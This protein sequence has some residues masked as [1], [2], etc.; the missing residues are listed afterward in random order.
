M[1]VVTHL[2]TLLH[3]PPHPGIAGR[4]AEV[5]AQRAAALTSRSTPKIETA[6]IDWLGADDIERLAQASDHVRETIGR[7]DAARK[8]EV[9]QQL[10]LTLTYYSGTTRSGRKRAYWAN[11]PVT[12]TR[13]GLCGSMIVSCP[14]K[15]PRQE[16]A[17]LSVPVGPRYAAFPLRILCIRPAPARG[18]TWPP[19]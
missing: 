2:R 13:S 10:P 16:T 17:N 4:I 18:I 8:G 9:C 3:Q 6:K 12:S 11:G 7:A 14:G 1:P 19:A 15:Q 5:N